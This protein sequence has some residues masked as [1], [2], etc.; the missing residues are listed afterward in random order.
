M[1]WC[2]VSNNGK[3][4]LGVHFPPHPANPSVV[5]PPAIGSSNHE[6]LISPL[7]LSD[8]SFAEG[9]ESSSSHR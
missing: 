6:A 2:S 3:N 5:W 1:S 7:E 8:W 9:R 4:P